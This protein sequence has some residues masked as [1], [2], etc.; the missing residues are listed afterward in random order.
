MTDETIFNKDEDPKA[1]VQPA[2]DPNASK[3]Q[4]QVTPDYNAIFKDK[5]AGITNDKGEQKYSDVFTALEALKVTQDHVRTLESENKDLR[6]NI[7]KSETI[8]EALNRLTTNRD[9]NTDKTQGKQEIDVE[10]LRRIAREEN[11]LMTKEQQAIANKNA[12]SEALI[13]KY[14]EKE[15]AKKAFQDKADTLGISFDFLQDLA[16]TSPKAVLAYFESQSTT[17]NTNK[18]FSQGTVN[19]E[20]TFGEPV[21]R[22]I[23]GVMYGSSTKDVLSA[24]NSAKESVMEELAN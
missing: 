9:Q 1:S 2:T 16:S 23:G 3:N 22:K 19:S 20:S 13:K 15:K 18:S 6:T 21:K 5:L 12:V 17:N 11:L 7:T 10:E 4:N 14:G 8:E 24:W